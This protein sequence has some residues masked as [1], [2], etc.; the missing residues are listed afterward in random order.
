MFTESELREQQ[1]ADDGFNGARFDEQRAAKEEFRSDVE[2]GVQAG[3]AAAEGDDDFAQSRDW[4]DKIDG[5][6]PGKAT[7]L[8]QELADL[9]RQM[10]A[11]SV[12]GARAFAEWGLRNGIGSRREEPK[13]QSRSAYTDGTIGAELEKAFGQ[14]NRDQYRRKAYDF[15]RQAYP[16][17]SFA[18][19][20]RSV[21]EF[22]DRAAKVG[23]EKAVGELA[24]SR[25][26]LPVT[27]HEVAQYNAARQEQ[28]QHYERAR[29]SAA[30]EIA[31]CRSDTLNYP[32]FGELRGLMSD[33][34][35]TAPAGLSI[36]D[37]YQTATRIADDI[38]AFRSKHPDFPKVKAQMSALLAAG[39]AKNLA[40]AYSQVTAKS[41]KSLRGELQA[42]LRQARR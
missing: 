4:L 1:P 39:K 17:E 32:R 27:E 31:E 21:A 40:D 36:Q 38:A 7:E 28:A 22:F 37:A 25:Y 30:R 9:D 35:R 42:Q 26:N 18:T 23:L 12:T 24:T 33:I 2:S 5:Y 20:T 8:M 41:A 14:A 13:A 16:G 29:Q 11:D 10:R 19:A 6:R 15:F 3:K 34:F